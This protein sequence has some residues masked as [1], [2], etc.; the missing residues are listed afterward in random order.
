MGRKQYGSKLT[1]QAGRRGAHGDELEEHVGAE[2]QKHQGQ[3]V[4][5][6]DRNNLHLTSPLIENLI[7]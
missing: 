7:G 2:D 6:D 5:R 4:P 1:G 3:Q